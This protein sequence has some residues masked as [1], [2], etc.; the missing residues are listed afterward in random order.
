MPECYAAADGVL[1]VL[2]TR[3][4]E[5]SPLPRLINTA[6]FVVDVMSPG[7]MAPEGRGIRSA[8]WVRWLHAM[9][10]RHVKPAGGW[11][12][13]RAVAINQEHMA[14]TLVAFS[15]VSLDAM[16][17]LGVEIGPSDM[18]AYVH[19]WSVVG[20][21]LG[22]RDENLPRSVS[23]ARSL[24]GAIRRRTHRPSTEG[25]DLLAALL[26]FAESRFPP[27][28]RGLPAEL[29]RYLVPETTAEILGLRPST[30]AR[31]LVAALRLGF[32]VRERVTRRFPPARALDL[33]NRR[34]FVEAVLWIE[35]R[36]LSR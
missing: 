14:G 12:T 28:V 34:R 36:A 35:G 9:V 18:E 13:T 20:H 15:Q 2:H 31:H 21:L 16:A 27:P 32:R 33:Y 1:G 19:A 30:R 5:S 29:V 7:A 23:E 17:K 4:L 3:T 25:R 6:R 22:V 10:R 11:D 8:Q 24:V 26:R